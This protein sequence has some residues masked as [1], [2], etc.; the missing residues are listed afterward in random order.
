MTAEIKL[1][2][3]KCEMDKSCEQPV[4]YIDAKGFVYCTCHGKQRQAYQ[5]CRKL[6]P[7]EINTLNAGQ[8]VKRY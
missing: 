2:P 8:P 1:H 4:T 7:H 6:R 3:L 5:R